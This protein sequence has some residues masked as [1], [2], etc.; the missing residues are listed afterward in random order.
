MEPLLNSKCHFFVHG[1]TDTLV[2]VFILCLVHSED[3]DC[4]VYLDIFRSSIAHMIHDLCTAC[5]YRH[6]GY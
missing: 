1:S 4:V 6:V 3:I 2:T 5:L